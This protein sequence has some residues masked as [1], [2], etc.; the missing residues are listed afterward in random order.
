MPYYL[1]EPGRTNYADNTDDLSGGADTIDLTTPGTGDYTLSV[2]GTAAVTVAAGTATGTGFAQA[3][4]GSPVTF[5]LSAAGTVTLTLNSGS[6][7]EFQ[8][9]NPAYQL[10]KG[11]D[12]TSLIENTTTSTVRDPE[13]T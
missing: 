7:D 12:A 6:F 5:N 10:E 11:S 8:S 1:A 9:G 13:S 3:T 2:T 4:E